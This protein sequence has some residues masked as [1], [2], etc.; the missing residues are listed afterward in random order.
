MKMRIAVGLVCGVIVCVLVTNAISCFGFLRKNKTTPARDTN[1]VSKTHEDVK[2]NPDVD[3]TLLPINIQNASN[4]VIAVV[5]PATKSVVYD[6]TKNVIPDDVVILM[7]EMIQ[8]RD[9]DYKS[10]VQVMSDQ[11]ELMATRIRQQ[12]IIIEQMKRVMVLGSN[13]LSGE[14]PPSP[15][16]SPVTSPAPESK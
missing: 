3:R 8:N 1:V 16:P 6:T 13:I 12:Q 14:V 11:L 9:R 7:T 5:Y 2:V 15:A 10:S 4:E